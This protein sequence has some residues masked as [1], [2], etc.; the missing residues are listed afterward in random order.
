MMK[1]TASPSW[2]WTRPSGSRRS[3]GRVPITV[4]A[5]P[6]TIK[7]TLL[8]RSLDLSFEFKYRR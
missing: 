7:Q 6:M 8:A 5:G 4:N 1:L 3:D 2:Q